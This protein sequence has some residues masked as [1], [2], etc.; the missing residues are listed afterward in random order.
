[1]PVYQRETNREMPKFEKSPKNDAST[2]RWSNLPTRK[3]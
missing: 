1:M 3:N 2:T